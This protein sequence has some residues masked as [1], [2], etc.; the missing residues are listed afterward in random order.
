VIGMR[1]GDGRVTIVTGVSRRAGI[2]FAIAR[3]LLGDGHRVLVHS[4]S[5]VDDEHGL[6]EPGG[7]AAVLRELGGEGERLAHIE[8]DLSETEAGAAV[9]DAAVEAFGAVDILVVNHAFSPLDRLDT[10]TAELLDRTW[11]TNARAAVLLAQAFARRYD[12]QRGDGRIVLFTSGQHREPM[13]GELSYAISKGALHQMTPTLADAL[14]DRG[15][16]VN[17]VNPGPVDTGWP[18]EQWRRR[19]APSWPAG[20][21]GRPDDIAYVVAWLC[22]RES[23]WVTGN[24]IDAEGGFRRRAGGVR[25]DETSP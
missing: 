19:L 10:T 9:V 6:A 15:I 21:W 5:A 4:W 1:D 2:G 13:P 14:A 18:S 23:A 22:S 8:A 24:V 3:R 20:R 16:T 11:R 25:A 12:E 7:T 17:A